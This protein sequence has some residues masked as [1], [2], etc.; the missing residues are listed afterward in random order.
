MAPFDGRPKRRDGVAGEHLVIRSTPM[1]P[2]ATPSEYA[3]LSSV[4]MPGAPL[5]ICGN[6][7]AGTRFSVSIRSGT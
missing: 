1:R 5:L 4:S 6:G 3:T 7:G 2:F